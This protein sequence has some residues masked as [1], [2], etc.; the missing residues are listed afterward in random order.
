MLD[1]ILDVLGVLFLTASGIYIWSSLLEK[2]INLKD[3]KFYIFTIILF[4]LSIINYNNLLKFTFMTIFMS[5]FIRAI[6]KVNIKEGIVTATYTQVLNLLA[7]LIFSIVALFI[8]KI[9]FE[10][11][12]I[13]K[14]LVLFAD[15]FVSISAIL[16]AK[17][18]PIRNLHNVLVKIVSGLNTEQI[19]LCILPLIFI[20]NIYLDIN[21]YKMDLLYVFILNYLTIY[22]I[23]IIIII[24]AKKEKEYTK[25]YD[26]YN[27]TLNS[28][29]EYEEILD[30]YRVSN[31]EN[32][33]QLLTVRSMISTKNKKAIDYI[34]EIV[35][36]RIKDDEKAEL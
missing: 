26:K 30:N 14:W 15:I 1:I 33:N 6:F 32:K 19:L 29:K 23:V 16:L 13:S 5:F 22:V 35:Q 10:V 18:K 3:Y 7:E 25:I 28:L 21:Y 36:N 2:K 31:H 9:N 12:D 27:T 34:D 24:L 4:I 17:I 8:L 11:E 20:F